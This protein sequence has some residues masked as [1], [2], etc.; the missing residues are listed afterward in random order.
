MGGIG[1][2]DYL[3]FGDTRF[4]PQNSSVTPSAQE[5]QAE[6]SEGDV[7]CSSVIS[8]AK[9]WSVAYRIVQG[10][11]AGS[12]AV[13]LTGVLKVGTIVTPSDD[14]TAKAVVTKVDLATDNKNWPLLTVSADQWFGDTEDHTY[15]LVGTTAVQAKKIAQSIGFSED[16]NSRV[17]SASVSYSA[18]IVRVADSVGTYV[19]TA[20]YGGRAEGNGTLVGCTAVAG[21]AADT[22]WTL[23]NE[24]EASTDN[25]SYGTSTYNVF[26]NLTA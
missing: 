15:S 2:I 8:A 4:E 17:N 13:D 26:R 6:D 21:G 22:G 19:K 1:T 11:T 18:Q 9:A 25:E 14:S 5:V 3:G 24:V 7:V 12:D 10:D 23:Q 20:I 16:T